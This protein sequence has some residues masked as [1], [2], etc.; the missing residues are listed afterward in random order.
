MQ[1][2]NLKVLACPFHRS[3]DITSKHYYGPLTKEDY[4][5]K[6]KVDFLGWVNNYSKVYWA[7]IYDEKPN[8]TQVFINEANTLF[9]LDC[10]EFNFIITCRLYD[11][12]KNL[13][14]FSTGVDFGRDE[15]RESVEQN[16][17]LSLQ[18]AYYEARL[19]GLNSSS[20]KHA[21]DYLKHNHVTAKRGKG[22]LYTVED[23]ANIELQHLYDIG[24]MK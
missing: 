13:C 24:L 16:L 17:Q 2:S 14:S 8:T 11:P 19:A 5:Y 12:V 4:S 6:T 15:Y 21:A 1:S 18:Q 3:K 10:W 22:S 20:L 23:I 7:R 9:T